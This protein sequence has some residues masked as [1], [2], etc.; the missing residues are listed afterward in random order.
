MCVCVC[1]VGRVTA[2]IFQKVVTVPQQKWIREMYLFSFVAIFQDDFSG[3]L[4]FDFFCPTKM[5]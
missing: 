4:K 5:P 1:V 3:R 2:T